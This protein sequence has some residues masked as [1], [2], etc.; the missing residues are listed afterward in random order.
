M[1]VLRVLDLH[2]GE[3][4]ARSTA[5][6]EPDHESRRTPKLDSLAGAGL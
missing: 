6:G 2:Q 3:P 4:P 1:E 5:N